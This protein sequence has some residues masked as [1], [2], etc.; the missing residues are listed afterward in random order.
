L[1]LLLLL[2][3]LI[4]NLLLLSGFLVN[5]L[6]RGLRSLFRCGNSAILRFLC[7]LNRTIVRLLRGLLI[8]FKLLFCSLNRGVSLLGC[9]ICLFGRS[10]LPNLSSFF[11]RLLV[12]L[13]GRVIRVLKLLLRGLLCSLELLFSCTV[14][15][16]ALLFNS[17]S[18][19]LCLLLC[20]RCRSSSGYCASWKRHG[21]N[22]R[23]DA[24]A[25]VLRK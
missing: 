24:L 16:L 2:S 20:V 6:K 18:F 25:C 15:R 12:A 8:L 19:G 13:I 3:R 9:G 23:S 21:L 22:E 5:R 17:L 10:P 7:R 14:C 4:F 11:Y 1:K